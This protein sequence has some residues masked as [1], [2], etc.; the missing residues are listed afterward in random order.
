MQW[1]GF[2]G[3]GVTIAP[4]RVRTGAASAETEAQ[5]SEVLLSLTRG[6]DEWLADVLG[7]SAS[8]CYLWP[9]FC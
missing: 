7:R 4:K 8:P 5:R 6:A 3:G 1:P 2:V 9:A